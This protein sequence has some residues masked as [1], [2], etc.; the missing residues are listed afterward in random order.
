[1]ANKPFL[2]FGCGYQGK[3]VFEILQRSQKD[4]K[5]FVDDSNRVKTYRSLPVIDRHESTRKEIP[6]IM[7]ALGN[8]NVEKINLKKEIIAFYEQLQFQF[9]TIIDSTASISV[10][11]EMEIGCI[12]H[13]GVT[14][15]PDTKI[16]KFS[17]I[18]TRASID[19]DNTI[20]AFVNICPGVV[21]AGNVTFKEGCFVGTGAIILP[22]VTIGKNA[23]IGAGAVVT[24]DVPDNVTV[25]GNPARPFQ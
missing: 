15:M 17:I 14:L 2:I 19:H 6:N 11:A 7:I 24:K 18:S 25:I 1:M 9:P 22:G 8:D 21:S 12:I 20:E 16:G 23:L 3:I 10:S 5:F 13:P 4:P